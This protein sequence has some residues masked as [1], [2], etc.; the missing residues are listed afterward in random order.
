MNLHWLVR[1]SHWARNP[2]SRGRVKLVLV[3]V[4]AC[5][6]LWGIELIWGWPDW[7]TVNRRHR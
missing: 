2:P 4:A 5:L 1:M 6:M 7:L 3:V